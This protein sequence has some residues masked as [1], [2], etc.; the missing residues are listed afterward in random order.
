M[1]ALC[2]E[3][4]VAAPVML[5][6]GVESS[7]LRATIGALEMSIRELYKSKRE[8]NLLESPAVLLSK[9]VKRSFENSTS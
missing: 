2:L 5:K 1:K 6:E 9:L 8:R 4:R 7:L 3:L